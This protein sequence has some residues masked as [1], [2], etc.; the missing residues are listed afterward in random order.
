LFNLSDEK[1]EITVEL[2]DIGLKDTAVIRDLWERK[3]LGEVKNSISYPVNSHG[4]RMFKLNK[5]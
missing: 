2:S 5:N 3:D 1:A 4:A